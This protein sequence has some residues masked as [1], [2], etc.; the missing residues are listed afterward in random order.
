MLKS[1]FRN[2]VRD[3][4]CS[5]ALRGHRNIFL[6]AKLQ[7]QLGEPGTVKTDVVVVGGGHAGSEACTAAAR[8][9]ANT[10]LVTPKESN[11]G[12]CS[13]NPSFG[14]IGKGT[15]LKEVDALDGVSPRIVDKAGIH[16][17]TLNRSR[18]PAVW[19]PRAQIDRKIYQREMLKELRNYNDQLKIRE[20]SVRDIIVDPN[21]MQVVG[22]ILEGTGEVISAS[23]V[24]LTTGTFLSAEIH[25]GLGVKPAGRMG[26]AAT[27]GLSRTLRDEL[28]FPLGR[29]KTGTPPRLKM[30]SINYEG[31]TIQHG[32]DPP[33]PFSTMNDD[34]SLKD[35]QVVCHLTRTSEKSHDILKANMHRSVHIRESVN[36]P[37]YCPS[38]ESKV[39][40]FTD[41]NSHQVW[42]EPEGLDSDLVYPNGL[43]VS[44]PEEVQ[45]EMLRTVPGLEG[46]EM[47]Q[48]GYGVEYDYVDPRELRPTLEAK[49]VGGLYLAGQINGTTGYEEA[50]AQGIIAGINAGLA[51]SGKH[52]VMKRNQGYIGVLIDDLVTMGVEE[53]YRMFTSRSEFRFTVRSD[54]AD[55]RLTELAHNELGVVSESRWGKF[56]ADRDNYYS[57]KD[58]L[59]S[60]TQSSAAWARMLKHKLPNKTNA[61]PQRRS[62]Y[63]VLRMSEITISDLLE[64]LPPNLQSVS[65]RV[66]EQVEIDAKYA[67]YISREMAAI[68]AFEEDESLAIP[69][70]MDYS[71]IPSLSTESR[72]LLEKIRPETVGQA[73]R[74]QG[75]TPAACIDLYRF[76]KREASA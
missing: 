58:A 64:G 37:R 68:K 8:A 40:R 34:V 30:S 27:F 56:Q 36:G 75:V 44:M 66:L 39:L 74:I 73:R 49:R 31:L 65:P 23:R 5:M 22:V 52:F 35:N 1:V 55:L 32:D 57:V 20:A 13:C 24:I 17:Q 19:G 69:R 53:P 76:V 61:D 63:A 41:K 38:I 42:L 2:T 60:W 7:A 71:R 28:S 62:A 51:P 45:L 33:R 15:L 59:L 72:T 43:S 54:N 16:F 29:L 9:G 67:P 3:K 25:V 70:E 11:I 50:A 21:T 10:L 46:V 14:G 18:G 4:P 48:P 26:E 12:V 6:D 47:T